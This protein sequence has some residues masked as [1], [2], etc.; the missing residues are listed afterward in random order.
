MQAN[1]APGSNGPGAE[2]TLPVYHSQAGQDRFLDQCVFEGMSGG[3]FVDVGAYD[4]VSFSNS[5]MFE[6]SRQWTGLCIEP[7]PSVFRYLLANRSATCLNLAAGN[8]DG[9]LPFVKV[10]G[11]G[12]MLSGLADGMD[13]RHV[14][15]IRATGDP[16]L[17]LQVPVRRLSRVLAEG[18]IDEVH[19]LSL[20]TEGNEA[21]VLASVD[22]DR[23]MIHVATVEANYSEAS[24]RILDLMLP[25][26]EV[27]GRHGV[28][29]FFINRMSPFLAKDRKSVV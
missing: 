5:L 7:N 29:L 17:V 18:G 15:R 9:S 4:G 10:A 19:Y 20:D 25:R 23:T 2:P 22:F 8:A 24:Y 6:L 16:S 14:E 26:F 3:V 12:E 13:A 27:A 21:D 28:D 1:P 11:G